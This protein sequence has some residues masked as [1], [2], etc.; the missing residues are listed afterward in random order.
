MLKL[1]HPKPAHICLWV[2]PLTLNHRIETT[3]AETIR[4]GQTWCCLQ[5][6]TAI[7]G[8]DRECCRCL[9]P[10]TIKNYTRFG[11]EN[12][13]RSIIGHPNTQHFVIDISPSIVSERGRSLG[14]GCLQLE[15]DA[16]PSIFNSTLIEGKTENDERW[17]PFSNRRPDIQ[18]SKKGVYSRPKTFY[19]ILNKLM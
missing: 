13:K 4:R 18:G 11:R 19:Q 17:P 12:W 10:R 9:C 3:D 8:T 1:S 6:R 5:S 16:I 2:I 14:F 7:F 15:E